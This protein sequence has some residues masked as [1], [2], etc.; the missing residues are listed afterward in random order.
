M[1]YIRLF[2]KTLYDAIRVR[3]F[4]LQEWIRHCCRYLFSHPQYLLLDIALVLSYFFKSPYRIVRE[5]DESH[6][7]TTVG[8]YG[9]LPFSEMERLFSLLL[10][11]KKIGTFY[12][13][14][15]GRGRIIL[16]AALCKG[17]NA[18]GV[19]CVAPFCKKFDRFIRHFHPSPHLHCIQS[20][21]T[22]VSLDKCDLVMI[23]P[24]ELET[25]Q[26]QYLLQTL[27]SL[28]QGAY[29]LAIGFTLPSA[30]YDLEGIM[31]LT[32]AWGEEVAVLH[33]KK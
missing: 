7:A 33:K 24:G 1:N 28:Q 11:D 13:L 14:G 4:L 21:Y 30:S 18:V 20:S 26:E 8:P 10:K 22:S 2:T 19:E 27:S 9:E 5:W 16:W 3:L 15:S 6:T 25:L 23:N 32:C 29:V 17:W 12:D 31:P